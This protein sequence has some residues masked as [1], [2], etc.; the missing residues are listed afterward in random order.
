MQSIDS[1]LNNLAGTINGEDKRIP[2]SYGKK[3]VLLAPEKDIAFTVA[4]KLLQS[5]E[6]AAL[7][8]EEILE[9]ERLAFEARKEELLEIAKLLRDSAKQ[10]SEMSLQYTENMKKISDLMT[11]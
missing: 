1:I 6:E 8:V 2:D 7:K 9:M 11:S 10:R 5:G 4:N 3:E